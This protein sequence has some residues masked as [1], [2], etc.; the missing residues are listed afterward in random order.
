LHV[1]QPDLLPADASS[2]RLWPGLWTVWFG[3][4]I[5]INAGLL[6]AVG[7][8]IVPY[9]PFPFGFLTLVVSLEAIFLSTFVMIAQNR[10]SSIADRRAEADYE[11]NVRAEA[12]IAR[13]THL[14]EMLLMH[15]AEHEETTPV[16]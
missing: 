12:E 1:F 9:D 16:A 5:A 8:G 11:V 15:H 13:L 10:Q 4:W 2:M 14:V 7:V 3:L 6:L